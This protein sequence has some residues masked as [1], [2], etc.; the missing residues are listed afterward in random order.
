MYKWTNQ[1]EAHLD[2]KD[3][4]DLE[5]KFYKKQLFLEEIL[6]IYSRKNIHLKFLIY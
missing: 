5:T 2:L 4:Y 1:N 3:Y 6:I